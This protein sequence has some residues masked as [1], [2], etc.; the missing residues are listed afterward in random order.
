MAAKT[1]SDETLPKK[2]LVL[3]FQVQEITAAK[4]HA[5]E[6]LTSK[7]SLDESA[8]KMLTEAQELA[9]RSARAKADA[10]NKVAVLEEQVRFLKLLEQNSACSSSPTSC[11]IAVASI[12]A[13]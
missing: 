9:A 5:E 6:A 3:L 1:D 13:V 11:G 2:R 8:K 7:P 10:E 4:E 12:T